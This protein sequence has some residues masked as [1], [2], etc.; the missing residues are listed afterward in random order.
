MIFVRILL[1]FGAMVNL[2]FLGRFFLPGLDLSTIIPQPSLLRMF[3]ATTVILLG[4]SFF[5]AGAQ[6]RSRSGWLVL[7]LFLPFLAPLILALL[8]RSGRSSRPG[9][10]R[11]TRPELV[12]ASAETL[13]E[14]GL[15]KGAEPPIFQALLRGD[16]KSAIDLIESGTDVNQM[17]PSE[18][19]AL[20]LSSFGGYTA[21]AKKLIESGAD[22]NAKIA[23][24]GD[25][26]A[27]PLHL[28]AMKGHTEV[29]LLLVQNGAN[30]DARLG[31][32][33]ETSTSGASPL[34][35]AATH[36]RAE[37]VKLLAKS[38]ADIEARDDYGD[39]PL[40]YAANRGWEE[41]VGTLMDLG[42]NPD[43]IDNYGR[44][45]EE[46]AGSRDAI[47]SILRRAGK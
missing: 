7:T 31:G 40:H 10:T 1:A 19:T 33:G 21:V 11:G 18:G 42:A 46:L 37:A 12:P 41:M 29:I 6:R 43:A 36:N 17:K 32:G 25:P 8:P 34:H 44:S 23:G 28:A 27:T 45:V 30:I 9:G 26:G 13:P 47:H 24:G 2:A 39:T 20:H 14:A 4:L 35:L 16:V 5:A 3:S 15:E 38:G 22:V